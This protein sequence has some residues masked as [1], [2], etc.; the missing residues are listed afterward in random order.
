[1]RFIFGDVWYCI[2]IYYENEFCSK[3]Y[4]VNFLMKIFYWFFELN[5]FDKCYWVMLLLV[6]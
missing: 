5:L 3:M 2:R 1:M 6:N 4:R